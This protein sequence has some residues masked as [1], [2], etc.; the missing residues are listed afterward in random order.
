MKRPFIFAVALIVCS[1]ATSA[2]AQEKDV[3]KSGDNAAKTVKKPQLHLEAE[4]GPLV[5]QVADVSLF[6]ADVAVGFHLV[7]N[8]SL[9]VDA[10]LFYAGASTS[11]GLGFHWGGARSTLMLTPGRFRI[12]AG[13]DLLYFGMERVTENSALTHPGVG[14]HA[15]FGFDII[16]LDG[17]HALEVFAQP[18]ANWLF[19]APLLTG[20]LELAAR[21]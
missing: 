3:A 16:E 7:A 18:E 5:G 6:G 14:A 10:K 11:G 15:H 9:S 8:H 2:I 17:G 19:G 12:G 1:V 13:V 4:S 21:F 20:S